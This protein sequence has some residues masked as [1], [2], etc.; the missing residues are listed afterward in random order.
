MKGIGVTACCCSEFIDII[1]ACSYVFGDAKGSR[2]VNSPWSTEIAQRSNIRA[3]CAGKR[4]AHYLFK[5]LS[6]V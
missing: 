2:H 5:M 1:A 6:S 3:I 4:T